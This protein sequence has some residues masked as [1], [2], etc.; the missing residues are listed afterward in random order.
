L[1]F[2]YHNNQLFIS[3]LEENPNNILSCFFGIIYSFFEK[4]AF[5][6]VWCIW[7]IEMAQKA[8]E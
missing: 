8:K 1:A 3:R 6:L 7:F 4:Y 2:L 5:Y